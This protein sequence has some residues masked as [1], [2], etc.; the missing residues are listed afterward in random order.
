MGAHRSP[1]KGKVTSF[2]M[3]GSGVRVP[4][5]GTIKINNL[6]TTSHFG[7]ALCPHYVRIRMVQGRG[8]KLSEHFGRL[9]A[10]F[11]RVSGSSGKGSGCDCLLMQARGELLE[12]VHPVG[13]AVDGL[14]ESFRRH[15]VEQQDGC[16]LAAEIVLE[17]ENLAPVSQRALRE[18]TD[19]GQAVQRDPRRLRGP[20]QPNW[21]RSSRSTMA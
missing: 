8:C 10:E 15:V 6:A 2:V 21:C 13:N 9:A 11:K 16:C 4:S 7:K 17:G 20:S 1:C 3:M 12:P 18:Q 19:L 5:C 14:V